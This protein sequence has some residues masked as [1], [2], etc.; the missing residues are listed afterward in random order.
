MRGPQETSRTPQAATTVARNTSWNIIGV[1]LPLVLAVVTIPVLI[2]GLGTERFG[3]LMI[4]WVVL[5]Y[6][7][8]FDLGLGRATTKFLAEDFERGRAV[9]A[10]ALLWTSLLSNVA[11]GILGSL[12]LGALTPPLVDRVL[13]V[14]PALRPETLGAFYLVAAAVPLVNLATAARGVLEARHSF[15]LL[16][17]L[18]VPTATLTQIAPLLVLPFSSKLTWLVG[19]LALSRLLGAVVFVVA[20]LRQIEA[21]F[22]G[23]FLEK[24]RL[25]ALFTYGGWL[26]VSNVIGPLM[27][28]ADRFFIGSLA[29]MS[30]VTYY[31]T[32]Y[33]AVTRLWILPHSL[34]RTV[35]PIFS[36]GTEVHRRTSIYSNALKYLALALA[37][38]VLVVVVFAPDL[39]RLWVGE[40]FAENSTLVLQILAIGV[41]V[42]SLALVPY[43]LIQGLGRP[44]I[45]AKFHLL[46]L[47]FYLL[48]LWY[49]VEYWGIVG[50][51]AAWT[52]RVSVD[53]LLLTLYVRITGSIGHPLTH[54]RLP[55]TLMLTSLLI[56][57]GWM[58]SWL[59]GYLFFK[60]VIFGVFFALA[61]YGTWRN[62]LTHHERERFTVFSRGL[63]ART[64]NV[65]SALGGRR[66]G[67]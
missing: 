54:S 63:V 53:G 43:T 58:L 51:A 17:V 37:P 16:N 20:A 52:V 30:A 3:V 11:L 40:A 7:G 44:D 6:F 39:L 34:T 47:P 65:Y 49:G 1:G 57:G 19:A 62:L 9:D 29:S 55:Q 42:N 46:E 66:A 41:L 10:R 61:G 13:N 59:T 38:V 2:R 26:T 67:R 60:I 56:G 24:K 21:P 12:V 14:P 5:G 4:A 33:E 32:P 35:F 27:V 23:P 15:G 48:F 8:L 36:A 25:R 28:Y 50:A 18:H 45:T 64:A 22:R 31:A